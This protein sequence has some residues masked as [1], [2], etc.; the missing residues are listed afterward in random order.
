MRSLCPFGPYWSIITSLRYIGKQFIDYD[1]LM[2]INLWVFL[3]N[4]K[5]R[6][7]FHIWKTR[8]GIM[9]THSTYPEFTQMLCLLILEIFHN[10][11]T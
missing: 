8:I 1:C 6:R 10:V 4:S 11:D 9:V 7:V 5:N 3:S 2:F